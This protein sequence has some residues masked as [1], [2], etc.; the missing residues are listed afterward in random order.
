MFWPARNK[1]VNVSLSSMQTKDPFKQCLRAA[2]FTR[3]TRPAHLKR[4]QTSP[5]CCIISFQGPAKRIYAR[6]FLA[7][8][9]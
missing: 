3:G 7:V 4:S 1:E 2:V 9:V 5:A 8:I 6:L